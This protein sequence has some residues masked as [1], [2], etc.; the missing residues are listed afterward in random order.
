MQALDAIVRGGVATRRGDLDA[1][2]HQLR[3][4]AEQSISSLDHPIMA[5]VA[6]AIGALALERGTL[7]DAATALDLA[8]ALRGAS[9]PYDAT[10]ARIRTA[11]ND[12]R[13][14]LEGTERAS[15][16]RETAAAALAQ[17]FLR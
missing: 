11:L 14:A 12:A 8:V 16:D 10:E 15:F 9:D 13:P 2:E 5:A 4:A 7:S 17:I 6:L 3:I 1:A